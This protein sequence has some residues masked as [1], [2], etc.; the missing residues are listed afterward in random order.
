MRPSLGPRFVAAVLSI[1]R[2]VDPSPAP[3]WHGELRMVSPNLHEAA[4]VGAGPA[5]LAAAASLR[6][7]GVRAVVVDK[8]AEVGST[9]RAHYDRLHLHTERALSGLPG[10]PIPRKHGKWVSRAGVVEY[11]EEY[12]SHHQI[13]LRL[14]TPVE[15]VEREG[16]AWKLATPSGP[17]L[18][19]AAVIAAGYNHTP[20]IPE[21]PGSSS[22]RGELLHSAQYKNAERFRGRHV[23]VVGTGNSGAEIAVDLVEGG[24]ASVRIAVRTPPNIVR[25]EVAGLATQRLGLALRHIPP[26]IVDPIARL[27][28]RLTVGDLTPYGLPPSPR[29]TYTRAREGQIPILDVG[30]VDAVKSG[31]VTIVSAV[32]AFDGGDV[33]LED[34]SRIQ[35]DAVIA[36]TGYLRALERL[37]G[38][39]GV[40]DA[41]GLP[42]AHGAKTH[43][44][45]PGMYFLGYSNPISGNLREIAIDARK[46]AKALRRSRS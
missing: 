3:A 18:A 12:A 39:L 45:A 37:V 35:P 40:L 13:E 29:G 25:R 4:I 7:V 27:V 1:L 43:P 30:L 32:R 17:L 34:G 41:H 44:A 9:W 24:A 20:R 6:A 33:V 28:Q 11:L 2:L 46:I 23:L 36:A 31:R 8:A 21:W 22:F 38:H 42:V 14:S 15:R 19:R 26:A 10:L 5:G 16:G